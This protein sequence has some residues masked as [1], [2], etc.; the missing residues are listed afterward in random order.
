MKKQT[1]KKIVAAV[2]AATMV[3]TAA[4][5]A[6]TP[7]GTLIEAQAAKKYGDSL[8]LNYIKIGEESTKNAT[9]IYASQYKCFIDSG[10]QTN[11]VKSSA[12]YVVTSSINTSG[13]N[14]TATIKVNFKIDKQPTFAEFSSFGD[15]DKTGMLVDDFGFDLVSP[16]V[17]ATAFDFSDGSNLKAKNKK[18][19]KVTS[20]ITNKKYYKVTHW[21][22]VGTLKYLKNCTLNM[23]VTYPKNYHNVVVALGILNTPSYFYNKDLWTSAVSDVNWASNEKAS[24]GYPT[25]STAK[26]FGNSNLYKSGLGTTYYVKSNKKI[27]TIKTQKNVSYIRL[28]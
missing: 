7:S 17:A 22:G 26:K 25:A 2:F 20:N 19:V 11:I 27:G 23:K 13:N 10:K 28:P 21:S 3:I 8:K 5:Q 9:G 4:P 15:T 18:N 1:F 14:K 16:S 12:S 24:H 6:W